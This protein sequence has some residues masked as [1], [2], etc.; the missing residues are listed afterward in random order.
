MISAIDARHQSHLQ[1]GDTRYAYVDLHKIL[2]PDELIGL[3]YSIRILLENVA[4]CSPASL[5]NFIACIRQG[6]PACE[7]PFYPNRLM[8]HDTT[9]LPALADF[10]G[11][12]DMVAEMGGAP[13]T[14]NP[15]IPAV[16]VIDH[17]V[18]VERYAE[19]DAVEKNLDIDYRRNSERY[20]FIKWAQKSLTNFKVVPPGTGIIHQVN[21]ESLAT[22][23][24]ESQTADGQPLLHPDDIVATDSHTP[25]INAIGVLGWGVGG[26]EGQAAMLGEPVPISFPEVVGIRLSNELRPG[27]TATDLALRI[28]Q[29]LRTKRVVGKFVEF[30]GPGLSKLSWAARGTLSNMAPEYG[31]TVVFFPFDDSTM[32]YMHLTGRSEDTIARIET[33][34]EAQGLWRHDSLP[35]PHFDDLIELD[36]AVIEPSVAGPHQ[37]HQW[38]KLADAAPSFRQEI[39]G[40][41]EGVIAR[42]SDAEA[43]YF[44]PSFGQALTHGAI[45]LAAI[46][47]CTNTA[48]P[49]QM[50]QAGLLAR[51]A[52]RRGL[53]SKPWVKTSLSPGSRVVADYLEKADLLSDFSALGFD[54][55]G[56]GCMTCI[57]NSGSLEEHMERFSDQGL[58]TVVV[59]SGNR[60]FEGRVNPRVQVGYLASPALVVAYALAGTINMDIQTEPL[61]QDAAGNDV[62]L[63]ELM[64]SEEQIQA[65]VS[66]TVRPDLFRQRNAMLWD[67]THHWQALSASGS[68]QFPWAPNSTYLRRPI[69]LQNVK[70]EAS[71]EL[72]IH[73]AR[74]LMVLGDNVTTDHISPASA[75]PLESQAGQWLIERGENPN[76][77]N[78]YST[79]RSNHEVMMRGAFVN[80]AVKNRLLEQQ[81]GEGG[82]AT[83]FDGSIQ[84]VYDAAL[85][86]VAKDMPLVIFAGFNYGAG[87]SRDWAAKAQAT[88]GVKAVVAQSFERIHRSNLIGM[89]ILPITFAA[90]VDVTNLQLKGDETLDFNGLETMQVGAN[91]L[92]LVI[93]R[94]DGSQTSLPLILQ[95]DSQQEI[96]YLKE[97]G[98]LPYVVRKVV[99]QVSN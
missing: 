86:Y 76:D 14:M 96:L 31:A 8:F 56:F 99:S 46:T 42:A 66:Q 36:L 47:S 94:A 1:V 85:S 78:Q 50:I 5:D 84:R 21:M 93:N 58:K 6:A 9:C 68:V 60:N 92:C 44:E 2:T 79:R 23:V 54:L 32:E 13:E 39:L 73:S 51:N 71:P 75:I 90:G 74:T 29:I 67:G 7:V 87:S 40:E 48:N 59:L 24:W 65:L 18:I 35:E 17:S 12:R 20:E 52:Q 88:L 33:Y 3:P 38:R 30:C 37:P 57:G 62:Y 10:A 69:Y 80:R 83:A 70:A 45:S 61:G 27:V 81:P 98:I 26:L 19:A 64:P 97:G 11:M 55:A 53:R 95:L 28:T 41:R 91:Q 34:L 25:M 15:M 63:H 82:F 22:V 77:L 89:G 49:S 4:R 16:L 43:E 72:S